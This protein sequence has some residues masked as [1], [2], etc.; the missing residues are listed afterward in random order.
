VKVTRSFVLPQS[1]ESRLRT[2]LADRDA[3]LA[4]AI[5]AIDENFAG[6]VFTLTSNTNLRISVTGSDGVTRS[7]N[8]TLA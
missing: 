7:V 6:A 8:L 2:T 1:T 4:T 5:N 3:A